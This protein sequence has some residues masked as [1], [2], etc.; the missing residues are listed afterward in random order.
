MRRKALFV[1]L[2]SKVKDQELIVIDE[3]K[4]KQKKTKEM[5]RLLEKLKTAGGQFGNLATKGGRLLVVAPKKDEIL[6]LAA[7][8]LPYV[9]I[10]SAPNLNALA[11]LSYK[12]LVIPKEAIGVIEKTFTSKK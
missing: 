6:Q 3:L 12:Y 7:R 1:A 8:N 4:L 5:T 10:L 11:V 9:N 2:S